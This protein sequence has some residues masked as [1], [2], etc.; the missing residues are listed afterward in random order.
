MIS[1]GPIAKILVN[2]LYK[3]YPNNQFFDCGSSLDYFLKEKVTRDYMLND[4]NYSKIICDFELGHNYTPEITCILNVFKRPYTLSQQLDAIK[5]QTIPPKQIMIWKN[6][7][8]G[9]EIPHEIK[10]DKNII[11]VESSYNFGV[12]ARFSLALLSN[13]EFVCVFD[14]DT[15]PGKKWFENCIETMYKV[16]GL[17]GT[18]GLIYKPD[19]NFY[20]I[21][22]RYGWD[23]SMTKIG[24]IL[25]NEI[26]YI[27]TPSINNDDIKQVDIV[28][29]SW[30]FKREWLKHLWNLGPI[31]FNQFFTSG[32]DIG[33]SCALQKIGINTYVPPHPINDI[34]MF[35][36]LPDFANMYGKDENAISVDP[37]NKFVETYKY[38]RT[39]YKFKNINDTH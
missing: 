36:S 11:I 2:Y 28:G 6:Y 9:V 18:I 13:T 23:N 30:F 21:H 27:D 26:K 35:G 19:T 4:N 39:F 15:I 33:F 22:N 8:E 29:P 16:N 12:W 20:E 5:N 38:F 37:N 24:Y 34:E 32:E 17:L 14:D 1:A 10:N 3:K 7:G 25:N 31:D